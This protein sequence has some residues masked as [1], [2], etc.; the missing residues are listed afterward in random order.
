MREHYQAQGQWRETFLLC[1]KCPTHPVHLS[2]VGMSKLSFM[3]GF[4]RWVTVAG[5]LFVKLF[6]QNQLVLTGETQAVLFSA[7]L[8]DDFMSTGKELIAAQP[9]SGIVSR[10][11]RL[12]CLSVKRCC[13]F[14]AW[15]IV[16]FH[17]ASRPSAFEIAMWAVRR[18]S[19]A[20]EAQRPHSTATPRSRCRSLT[21]QAPLLAACRI[22][23]SVTARQ[24]QTYIAKPHKK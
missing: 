6:C 8:D 15:R 24:M 1:V 3:A 19:F 18:Q 5:W 12:C 10:K 20:E 4:C 9:W 13:F 17:K 14:R 23:L 22:W 16:F 2:L 7:M 11:K 21:E